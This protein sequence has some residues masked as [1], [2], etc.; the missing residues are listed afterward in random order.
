MRVVLK[1]L[2]WLLIIVVVL[3]LV[4]GI[5][6]YFWLRGALP[7]TAGTV[8][9]QGITGSVEILR[10]TDAVPHISAANGA[11]AMFGLGYAHAQDRLWQMEFQRRIAFE[12]SPGDSIEADI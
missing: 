5:G 8:K 7:Q 1:I 2:R 12:F 10:D 6:G 11:D 4:L 3:V 9:V